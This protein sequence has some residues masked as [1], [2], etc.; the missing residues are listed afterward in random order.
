MSQL[1]VWCA[2]PWPLQLGS[3]PTG[4]FILVGSHS[5]GRRQRPINV[6]DKARQDTLQKQ[7]RH[8]G[9]PHTHT[10]SWLPTQGSVG[11]RHTQ[12]RAQ[13]ST[14]WLPGATLPWLWQRAGS[15]SSLPQQAGRWPIPTQLLTPVSLQESRRATLRGSSALLR[16]HRDTLLLPQHTQGKRKHRRLRVRV[17]AP[18]PAV[19]GEVGSLLIGHAGSAYTP[20]SRGGAPPTLCTRRTN[21]HAHAQTL[22]R[23]GP[24]SAQGPRCP[25]PNPHR[26]PSGAS[27][28]DPNWIPPPHPACRLA[29]VAPRPQG[30]HWSCSTRGSVHGVRVQSSSTEKETQNAFSA[31]AP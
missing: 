29:F 20:R 17:A 4:R 31:P 21:Y 9:T 22:A 16:S 11:Q 18:A 19:C 12:P 8:Y 7:P 5:P 26:S 3:R 10:H 27:S 30:H 13:P 2:A 14:V 28:A 1:L 25:A 6:Q 23:L 24:A 15:Y